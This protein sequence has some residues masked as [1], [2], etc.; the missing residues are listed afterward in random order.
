MKQPDHSD[1]TAHEFYVPAEV[2]AVCEASLAT[3]APLDV[4]RLARAYDNVVLRDW[5]GDLTE[6]LGAYVLELAAQLAR[7]YAN[8]EGGEPREENA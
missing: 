1:D 8:Q 6:P 4:E 5:K 2:C 3:P 7:A